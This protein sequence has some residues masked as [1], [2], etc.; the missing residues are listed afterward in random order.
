MTA[1]T[2]EP[3]DRTPHR[4]PPRTRQ[5]HPITPVDAPIRSV[6]HFRHLSPP[7]RDRLFLHP[8][9]PVRTDAERHLVAIALG[10]TLYVPATRDELT[11]T[12]TR[13]AASGVTSMVIDLEDAVDD[14][15][16]EE[17][18][19]ATVATLHE[20][21]AVGDLPAFLFVRV[22]TADQIRTIAEAV[23][24]D[25]VLSGFVLPKFGTASGREQLM[26]VAEASAG[27]TV[28]F[29]AMPVL[30]SPEVIYREIRDIELVRIREM[31][32]AYREHVLAVRIG[33]TDLCGMFGI[34][35]DRDLTIYDVRVV[36]DI[37]AA[38]VN[39]LGRRDGSGF[40]ISGP[41]WEYFANHERMFAPRL[42][43]TPFREQN[44]TYFR[45]Q[46][47][48]RDLD[49]LLREIAL[50]RANGITGKTVIH[51]AHVGPVHALSTVSHEEYQD[52][53]DI[54]SRATGGV[55]S[56]RY[57]NKMN[58]LGP[59]RN[60]A[61]SVLDRAAVFGVAREEVNFVDLLTAWSER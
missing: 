32:N 19:A 34:R 28:P 53:Q 3:V 60:W 31:L 21:S 41:V 42:R 54:L 25:S 40:V 22:R 1:R 16:Q 27:R 10:A 7:T 37:I 17:A 6:T 15:Q 45:Q 4:R 14:H 35:R 52:A 5:E 24:G 49:G 57:G 38:I 12:I 18:L 51:P 43:Q 13:R 44:A 58:E 46:L 55:A 20:L 8:P 50:D 23:P 61:F 59:H 29:Y 36:A 56:S 47:V 2:M 48:S 9:Q 26:A 33:A 30:E 39:L 11:A